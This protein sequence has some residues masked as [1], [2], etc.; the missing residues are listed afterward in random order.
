MILKKIKQLITEFRGRAENLKLQNESLKLQNEN[1]KVQN[2]DIKAQNEDIKARNA[3]LEWAHIFHDTIKDKKW[4][5]NLGISPGR[6]AGN[7][8]FLYVLVK[9]LSEYK[10]KKIIE[11]GL[12]ESSKIVSSF[13]N[14]ELQNSTHLIV[15]QDE[16]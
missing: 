11:F 4:L 10:P 2:D 12:G 7:Y 15:E 6:W 8:S 14:N 9:I 13:L 1:L 16:T 3:E 5:R